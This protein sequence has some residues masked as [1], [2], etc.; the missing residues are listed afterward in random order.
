MA[1]VEWP[2]EGHLDVQGVSGAELYRQ[3]CQHADNP[4]AGRYGRCAVLFATVCL[5]VR[6]VPGA[7]PCSAGLMLA[8][9]HV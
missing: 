8:I 5:C 2:Q 1:G 9:H 3:L 7:L 4:L 6:L